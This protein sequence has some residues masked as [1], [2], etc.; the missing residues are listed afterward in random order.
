VLY[1]RPEGTG[2][3]IVS[4]RV[5]NGAEEVVMPVGPDWW[6]TGNPPLSVRYDGTLAFVKATEQAVSVCL[7]AP[8]GAV[9]ELWRG[10]ATERLMSMAWQPPGTHVIV[11]RVPQPPPQGQ[12][13][14]VQLWRLDAATGDASPVGVEMEGIRDLSVSRDGRRVAFTAG[15]PTREVWVLENF[16]PSTPA[17]RAARAARSRP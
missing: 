6:L 12:P 3:A 5:E 8:D 11:A 15:W 10:P 14:V 13:A 2:S 9:R 16:L 4:R 17:V 7:R 1:T